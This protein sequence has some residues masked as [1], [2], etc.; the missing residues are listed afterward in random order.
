MHEDMG[1]RVPSRRPLG[2]GVDPAA[3]L[4]I[5]VTEAQESYERR[6]EQRSNCLLS[7]QL[8]NY[9]RAGI[10]WKKCR[11]CDRRWRMDPET[12][13]WRIDDADAPGRGH[14]RPRSDWQDPSSH[15]EQAS[16]AETA[17]QATARVSLAS[18]SRKSVQILSNAN[19]NLAWQG[20]RTGGR[21]Q[22]SAPGSQGDYA[23]SESTHTK[24]CDREYRHDRLGT[25]TGV[26][27]L[28]KADGGRRTGPG[29][30]LGTTTIPSESSTRPGQTA[31][32]PDTHDFECS[33]AGAQ[34]L[35][36]RIRTSLLASSGQSHRL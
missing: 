27:S 11:E 20:P 4:P 35:C 36:E 21:R 18:S 17:S 6:L 34:D 9:S 30:G 16:S 23:A 15:S 19:A 8:S 1:Y 24:S 5:A 2:T 13:R 10:Q 14:P 28:G 33:R 7:G 26:G 22:R 32:H 31:R 3:C 29:L 25:G 12:R